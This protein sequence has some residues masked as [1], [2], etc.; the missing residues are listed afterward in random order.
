MIQIKSYNTNVHNLKIHLVDGVAQVPDSVL[1]RH[2][3]G[4]LEANRAAIEILL[5]SNAPAVR[6]WIPCNHMLIRSTNP[7][8][9]FSTQP[10]TPHLLH[11][12]L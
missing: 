2:L 10:L 1:V 7:N 12:Q 9:A 8:P 3:G 5:N 11:A 6:T 4:Q